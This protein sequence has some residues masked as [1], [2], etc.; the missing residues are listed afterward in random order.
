MEH[1]ALLHYGIKGMKWG[2]RRYQ[3]KD[4][5]LTPKGEARY[6]R[7][8]RENAAKK[9]ENRI[10][11]SQ[12]DPKRWAKEDLERTKRTVDASANLAKELKKLDES[13]TSKPTPKRMDLSKMSDKEM[14][15]QINRELLERQYN[16]LFAEVPAA[17]VSKGREALKTTLST[18]SYD[19]DRTKNADM[20]YATHHALDKHQYNALFNRPIPQTVYDKDGKAIGTGSFMKYRIDNS[21]KTDLKVASE[22]SGAKVFMDLYKK[23]RDFYNFV[24]DRERMQGYF[25][26]DKY[27]FKGYREAAAVLGKMR[28]PDYKPTSDDLQTVYRMFNYVIPYDGQGDSRKGR[29]MYNQRT[30][31]FHACKEAGYGAV[32]DTND[33][34]YGG[35]KAKSP[36]IVFDM[37][38]VVPKDVYRTNLTDQKFSTLVLVGR[39]LLGL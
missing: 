23:D 14:R 11:L 22:D 30:K 26:N 12:P 13:T 25:V 10:D 36:I 3:N 18:L 4:G 7:D 21:L 31:F 20:F 39:K 24:T 38:Q 37:E 32:L 17:Q 6:D 8:K 1:D 33:A 5:S 28:E 15:D 2:V 9:K 35:F 16:Q 29:D 19:K 34:I 27:K